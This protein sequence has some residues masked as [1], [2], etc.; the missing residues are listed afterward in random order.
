MPNGVIVIADISG[1]TS[2]LSHS[3]LEPAASLLQT[4]LD[5]MLV[6]TRP[7]LVVS[8]LEGDAVLSYA[9]E[10][11]FLRGQ[12]LVEMIEDTYVAFRRAL[13][14][15]VLN[16]QCSCKACDF[17][18]KL[19]LKF[20]VH[21]GAF[22]LLPL[23]NKHTEMVGSDVNLI[24]RLT[25][26][27]ITQ[28]TGRLA[29]VAYT[30]QA[31]DQLGLADL[32]AEMPTVVEAYD[33]LGEVLV[34]V[35][36]M[37]ELWQREQ[38][39][40][41]PEVTEEGALTRSDALFPI[42]QVLMWDTI[43]MPE[44]RFLLSGQENAEGVRQGNEW[45]GEGSSYE[46]IDGRHVS[47]HTIYAWDPPRQYTY[48][49]QRPFGAR[50]WTTIRVEPRGDQAHLTVLVGKSMKN[51]GTIRPIVDALYKRTSS[52]KVKTG[53]ARLHEVVSAAPVPEVRLI[54]E[55]DAE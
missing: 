30:Q 11:A 43:T 53:L 21:Y 39:K 17:V 24:H 5:I 37:R 47:R 9:L 23:G 18:P 31:I 8:R 38:P 25:K 14:Q 2:F 19:D 1:F 46:C 4:L 6:N 52:R 22:L 28:E 34:F 44:Y 35:Q 49:S 55:P 16:S 20:F 13:D 51:N 29:Y 40:R 48:E 27:H 12:T 50:G 15:L 3:E 10:G 32:A 33:H 7:P 42:S 36:D 41:F 45:I 54:D 26:N